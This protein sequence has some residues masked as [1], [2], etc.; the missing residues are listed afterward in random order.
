M[1]YAFKCSN[2]IKNI[3]DPV[4][5]D[6]LEGDEIAELLCE[7]FNFINWFTDL[8]LNKLQAFDMC[9]ILSVHPEFIG[10]FVDRLQKFTNEDFA[11]ANK[12]DLFCKE[13]WEWVV[14]IQPKLRI[15]TTYIFNETW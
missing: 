8:D 7:D 1:T 15:Y 3:D 9:T 12:K 4:V 2:S 11:R 5:F 6:E 13:E 14:T 10:L